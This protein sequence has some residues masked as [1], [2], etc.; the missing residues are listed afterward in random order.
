MV[1]LFTYWWGTTDPGD[2]GWDHSRHHNDREHPIRGQR[3]SKLQ[4]EV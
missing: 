2:K 3:G 4:P 1:I